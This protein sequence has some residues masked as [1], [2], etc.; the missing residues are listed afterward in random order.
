MSRDS[1]AVLLAWIAQVTRQLD[2]YKAA[3]ES[4]QEAHHQALTR[5]E[6]AESKLAALLDGIEGLEKAMRGYRPDVLMSPH[7]FADDLKTLR[8]Q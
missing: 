1:A 4:M 7:V 5:A 2:V 8:G 6:A 3:D